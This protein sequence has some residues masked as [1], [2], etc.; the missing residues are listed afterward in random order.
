MDHSVLIFF[1]L[2]F[3]KY[4]Q[5]YAHIKDDLTHFF[6]DQGITIVTIQP[7]FKQELIS[8]SSSSSSKSSLAQCLI[9]C[10]STECALKTCCSL[11]ELDSIVTNS[12]PIDKTK[13]SKYRKS[14]NAKKSTGSLLSLNVSSLAKFRK[15]TT[16]ELDGMK[17]SV[18]E[19]HVGHVTCDRE[20]STCTST[21]AIN[22]NATKSSDEINHSERCHNSNALN[23]QAIV[24]VIKEQNE[25]DAQNTISE[26]I[27][28]KQ[29]IERDSNDEES[30]LKQTY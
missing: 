17:K 15:S 30:A 1:F 14:K 12:T 26:N 27:K 5:V 11:N 3:C 25:N 16:S 10:Q 7:E 21:Q 23:T 28:D 22:L 9:G 19:T 13:Q 24:E 20:S 18:S 2:L 8:S 6:H 4:F 29:I